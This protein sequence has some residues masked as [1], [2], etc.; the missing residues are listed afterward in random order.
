MNETLRNVVV[1]PTYAALCNEVAGHI[2]ALIRRK[3]NTVLGLATGSTPIGVYNELVRLHSEEGLYFS[4][5]TTFNLNKYFPMES[6][7]PQSYH[8]FMREH[9]FDHINCQ[10]WHVPDGKVRDR[11]QVEA[12]CEAYEAKI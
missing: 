1:R 12:D 4:R 9:L 8:R 5:V 2:A 3:P 11:G 7:A 10:S 6:E